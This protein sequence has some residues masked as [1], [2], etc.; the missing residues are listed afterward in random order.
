MPD[1]STL[2]SIQ[3]EV[4]AMK[5]RT[6]RLALTAASLLV[7]LSLSAAAAPTPAR[8]TKPTPRTLVTEKGPMRS[9]AQDADGMAW[10]GRDYKV[11]VRSF[12]TGQGAI[13]GTAA[14]SGG[15]QPVL[16]VA[17]TRALWTKFEGGNSQ[18][19]SLWTAALGEHS[20]AIDLFMTGSGDP[21]GTYLA[22]AAGQ[23]PTLLYGR[24]SEG[25]SPPPWPPA[26]CQ[27]LEAS[28]GVS[29]VTG[30]W[31]TP[32]IGG[33]PAP[34]L[35]AFAAHD[36]RSGRISQG[37]LA[38]A[39]AASPVQTDLGNVPR[40]DENGP[41]QVYWFLNEVHLAASVNPV[42]TVKAIALSFPQLAVLV[43]RPDGQRAI[44]RYDAEDGTPIGTAAVPKTTA[45][46]LSASTSGIVYR[47]G[48]SIYLLSGGT[49]KLIWKAG[50]APIGLSIVGKRIA[51][52]TNASGKGRIVALTLK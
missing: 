13:V 48:S 50:A 38:L 19:S 32:A 43:Q 3:A 7:L 37:R 10:I 17:G 16:A 33:I 23:G 36:P 51:W 25:C 5:S 18:E 22:G 44:E 45:S 47:V 41:V 9:F 2:A 4:R 39:P 15:P 27:R 12:V 30:Q 29:F 20:T 34:A 24:T 14:S 40:V 1:C 21:G 26:P 11:H 28:G 49:S 42:G 52:A 35:I 31:Q 6:K 8:N 46:L